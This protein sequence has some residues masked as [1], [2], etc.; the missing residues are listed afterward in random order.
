M[1]FKIIY[2]LAFIFVH[3]FFRPVFFGRENIPKGGT[4]ICCNHTSY[5][6]AVFLCIALGSKL[7]PYYMAKKELFRFP[8]FSAGIRAL[9]AFP[10]DRSGIDIGALKISLK[11]LSSG[12]MLV[13]FPEGTRVVN[14]KISEAKA[15]A[16]MLAMRSDCL[17]LPVYIEED[18]HVF[19]KNRV[20][21]G[22][23]FRVERPEGRPTADA[24][25]NVSDDILKRIFDLKE[26]KQ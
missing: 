20:I 3:L 10:V 6:D 15:G 26:E 5:L 23:P 19:R 18:K 12:G 7:R 1:F 4:L 17:V 13:L 8:V 16:G 25:K 24:Y 2:A 9:G 21:I 11:V 14:G 22:E